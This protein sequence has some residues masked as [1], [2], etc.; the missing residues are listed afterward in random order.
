M[1]VKYHLWHVVLIRLN[2]GAEKNIH[3]LMTFVLSDKLAGVTLTLQLVNL[4]GASRAPRLQPGS[5]GA[6]RAGAAQLELP[7]SL[8]ALLGE[9]AGEK[10]TPLRGRGNSPSARRPLLVPGLLSPA[11]RNTD[12]RGRTVCRGLPLRG[13][14]LSLSSRLERCTMHI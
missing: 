1:R 14:G 13:P 11:H 8:P 9:G 6:T 10:S 5:C 4:D 7:A 3:S 12:Q 2:C